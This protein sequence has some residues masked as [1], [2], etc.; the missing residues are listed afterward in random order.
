MSTASSANRT[1]AGSV[2]GGAAT[3]A[4]IGTMIAPGVGTLIGAS[5]GSAVGGIAGS[6]GL[7]NKAKKYARKARKVQQE[8][9]QNQEDAYYLQLIREA[10]M[11]R[12]GSLAASVAYGLSSSSLATSALSSIGSQ[13]QYSVQYTA[14]DQRLV[15][16]YNKYM[17]KAG[18]YAKAAQTTLATGQ[19]SSMAFGVGAAFASA[20]AA[21]GSAVNAGTTV[22]AT[23]ITPAMVEGFASYTPEAINALYSSTYATTLQSNWMNLAMWQKVAQPIYQGVNRYNQI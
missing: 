3:G 14:N 23:E 2:A 1:G 17:K 21:A 9:E 5:I 12:S 10:R 11:A 16:L 22:G 8:R 4:V 20:G 18:S 13:S 19:I 7:G 6:L 15:K